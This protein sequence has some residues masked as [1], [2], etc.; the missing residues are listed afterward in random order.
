MQVKSFHNLQSIP[1]D[2]LPRKK[3]PANQPFPWQ[4]LIL[5]YQQERSL[6]PTNWSSFKHTNFSCIP[7]TDTKINSADLGNA[8]ILFTHLLWHVYAEP[9]QILGDQSRR[10]ETEQLA[11]V[12][13]ANGCR[14]FLLQ[15]GV[16]SKSVCDS[17]TPAVPLAPLDTSASF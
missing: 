7:K 14:V 11:P 10:T 8:F 15:S 13:M 6:N 2:L 5:L 1:Q 9:M 3:L 4:V 17:H 12:L 16:T